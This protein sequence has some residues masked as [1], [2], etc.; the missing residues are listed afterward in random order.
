MRTTTYMYHCYAYTMLCY[1]VLWYVM[2][3]YTMRSSDAIRFSSFVE[4][5]GKKAHDAIHR[6]EEE[7]ARKH[8][9]SGDIKRLTLQMQAVTSE[10]SKN[11]WAE[12]ADHQALMNGWMM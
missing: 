2:L 3:Y 1:D 4:G 5:T 7:T 11:R 9:K 10:I 12:G 6:A 8:E